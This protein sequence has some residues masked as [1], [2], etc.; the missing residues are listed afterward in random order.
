MNSTFYLKRNLKNGDKTYTETEL[1]TASKYVVVLAEP[2]AGK[3]ELMKSLAQQLGA[4]L[5]TANV[6]A[7]AGA[8]A[9]YSPLVIDAFDEL[10]KVDQSGIHKLLNHAKKAKPSGVIISSRSS[11]WGQA[12]TSIF[13]QFLGVPPL[14]V[15]LCEF[16][17]YEQ[18]AIFEDHTPGEDFFEFQA[19]VARFSLEMLLPNPLFLKMFADAYLESDRQFSNKRSIFDLAVERLAK[20]VSINI[21]RTTSLL[22]IAQKISIS[23][24][25]F[26]KLLLSGADGISVSEATESRMYPMLSSL[27]SGSYS[28]YGILATRL[29]KPGDNEDQH[30][31]I[32][33]I[34]AEYCAADYL[35]K[36]IADPVDLLTLAKCLPIIAPNSTVRDELRG[37]L[38][39]MAALGNK[40][41]Q[42]AAIKLDPYAVL[43]NGDPS[44]LEPSSKRLLLSQLKEIEAKDPNF[45]RGDFWRNFSAAGFFTQDVIEEI[46]PILSIVNKGSLR[47]LILELLAVSSESSQLT[48]ELSQLTLTPEESEQTRSLASRCLLKIDGYSFFNDLAVLIFEASNIS[49]NISAKIIEAVG[50]EKF[51]TEY[52]AGYFRVC[53]NLY[54]TDN[55]HYERVIGVRYF[56]KHLISQL[57]QYTIESLLDQLSQN[58]IC[59]CGGEDYE[60]HCRKGISKIIGTMLDRYFEL[61]QPPFDPVRV[62]QWVSNLNFHQYC[63]PDQSKA[64]QE[65]QENESL[66]QSIIAYVL[67]N[68]TDRKQIIGIKIRKF[69]NH[70]HSH[71]GLQLCKNDYIFILDLAFELDNVELWASFIT[72]HQ[73]YRN[74]EDIGPDDLRKHMRYQAVSKSVFMCEWVRFNRS[75]IQLEFENKVG[76]SKYFRG[77]K[78]YRRKQREVRAE[79]IDFFNENRSMIENGRH[80]GYLIHFAELM[81]IAPERIPL[82]FD[83]EAIIHS[84]LRNC[85]NFIAQDTPDLS[86][87]A[88]LQCASK[89]LKTEVVFFASCIEIM[90][91]QGNLEGV[92]QKILKALRT[93]IHAGYPA[94]S[95]EERDTLKAEVD[96]IIFPDAESAENYLR[97]YIEPQLIQPCPQ[98]E[99]WMLSRDEVFS[100]SRGKLSIEWIRRFSNL[101]IGPLDMLFEVAIQYACREE[102]NEIIV[103]RCLEYMSNWPNL[104][105]DG[106]IDKMRVFWLVRAFYF[107]DD[108]PKEYWVWLKSDKDNLLHFD[109]RSDRMGRSEYWPRLTSIKV[110]TI[111]EAFADQWSR[112]DLPD[113]WETGRSKE[114]NAYRFLTEIIRVIGLDDPDD[115]IPVLERLLQIQRFVSLH[116]E[117]QSIHAGQV[118]KKA[119]RDFEPPTPQEIVNRLDHDVVVTVEGLRQLVVH[120]LNDFQRS[121]TGGEF[122]SADRFYE[123]GDRLDE[124]RS[125]EIIAERL[126]LKLEPQ[127]I[128]IT[129]EH[130]LKGQNRSDFTVSKLV[131]GRRRL[132]VTEVKGQWHRE[133]YAAASA[134]LNER[135]SIHPDAEQQGIFLVIWFGTEEKVAGRKNHSIGS[136][137]ELKTSIE[138]TLPRALQGL[139]DVFVLDVSRRK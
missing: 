85:L 67:G 109:H 60:C 132:L 87:L 50:P 4:T 101:A 1:L 103:D 28:Y 69:Q 90:R 44:Q 18:R 10:A 66:R 56:I 80:W 139:I 57:P 39:W 33:K 82:E 92:D 40:P 126:N 114:E 45:R 76:R 123:K 122:N 88:E 105:G 102:L 79:N 129:P 72:S 16:N 24:E 43:A 111:L 58:L 46:K 38:G 11:E 21:A 118:R 75:M 41:V 31:P 65:L 78:R 68:L 81:L 117:L 30:R 62:W 63:R 8:D 113:Y 6:F 5:V 134:Q 25:A 42:E 110:E 14:V 26:A 49:L 104:N 7:F 125:T 32:H 96:R 47:T 55:N 9:E 127:G 35:T 12:S 97:L 138:A 48:T 94:V 77:R 73:Y 128:S 23:S 112:V 34:V 36:R 98:P 22:P 93:N 3:S 2:G 52:L 20:E 59:N 137:L 64:V 71:S 19:E 131:G 27:F 130:Q 83:D 100:H 107:L 119:L 115:A 108:I 116:K 120:E 13:E 89:R 29:F 54:P 51:T 133:L 61:T 95:T 70:F 17:Q 86:E 135:Y 124:V 15:W 84:A 99:V 136:A 91:A 37:L 121:I 53:A 74:K 106:Y